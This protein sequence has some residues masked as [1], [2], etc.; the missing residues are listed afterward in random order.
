MTDEPHEPLHQRAET[1]Q[2]TGEHSPF[3]KAAQAVMFA[4]IQPYTERMKA[5]I[6][7][8]FE[9]TSTAEAGLLSRR[10]ADKTTAEDI[11]RAA[12]VL[13]HAHLE[14]FLRTLGEVLLPAGDENFFDRIPLAGLA[15]RPEKFSLGKLVRHKGKSVDDVLRESVCEYLDRRTFNDTD[16]ISQ[17]LGALGVEISKVNESFP[18]IQIMM[19]RRHQ[20]VHR[21]DRIRPDDPT[22]LEAITPAEVEA[23]ADATTTF[24]SQLLGEIALKLPVPDLTAQQLTEDWESKLRAVT[25]KGSATPTAKE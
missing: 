22:V 14:D 15:G 2:E 18:T 1:D 16:E 7:R 5:G 13:T 10:P 6:L 25:E 4:L 19:K 20:I 23:W 8:V 9:L 24:I 17:L 21:V 11:L 3:V 12:V